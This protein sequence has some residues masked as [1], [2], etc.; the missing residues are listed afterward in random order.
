MLGGRK[1]GKI[2]YSVVGAIT[3]IANG[4]F[5]SGGGLIAVPL[6]KHSNVEQRKAQASS[7]AITLPLSIVS[8]IIYYNSGS[9]DIS[10]ALRYVPL[11]IVGAI[12]GSMLLKKIPTSLLRKIFAVVMI[13][14]GIRLVMR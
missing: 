10:E 13:Y 8:T 2:Y 7:I 6:L 3:G 14:Y 9:I 11:G 4:L 12:I 1:Y 5:G